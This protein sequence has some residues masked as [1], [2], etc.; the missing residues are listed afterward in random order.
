MVFSG[1]STAQVLPA[2][3]A[4]EDSVVQ[5]P[6]NAFF[7]NRPH[8][9]SLVVEQIILAGNRVTRRP[10]IHRELDFRQ[11]S[12][13]ALADT[14]TLIANSRNRLYNTRLFITVSI[15]L[16]P[17]TADSSVCPRPVIAILE[18]KERWYIFPV[19]IF[20]L[21]D[22]SINEWIYNQGADI[23]RINYGARI[24]WNNF[25]GR[26]ESVKLILQTGFTRK[27]ELAYA[28]PYIGQKQRQGFSLNLFHDSNRSISVAS[29]GNK[30]KFIRDGAKNI[31][32]RYRAG[33]GTSF[34]T[35]FYQYHST[36][37]NYYYSRVSDSVVKENPDY[38]YKGLNHQGYVSLHYHY[39]I[40]RRD[41]RQ[42]P[43]HGGYFRTGF[44]QLIFTNSGYLSSMFVSGGKF[45]DLGARF[46]TAHAA[47]GTLS[48]PRR[49]PY[50]VSRFLGFQQNFVRGYEKYVLEGFANA[51]VKN[52]V[53][54]RLFQNTIH[55]R[56]MP[57]RQFS[58]IP[59][60]LYVKGYSDAGFVRNPFAAPENARLLNTFLWGFGGGLDLVTYY[61]SVLRMEYSLNRQGES[62]FYLQM[63]VE[64]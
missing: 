8:C 49:Q 46:Y 30:Q 32:W 11:G 37:I 26:A 15:K 3:S 35:G 18:F 24:E 34:R 44:D 31:V 25:R 40:D 38:F 48:S 7:L 39:S 52:T 22:R 29:E 1:V 14:A 21:S 10:I 63:A 58:T 17:A 4:R 42:Y 33:I 20:E 9:D 23:R 13:I 16:V 47:S 45:F 12:K 27:L 56:Y 36:G 6:L 61:D 28:I 60:A 59:I 53:R 41:I 57:I 43:L 2:D 62:G 55:L 5:L 51:V 64:I 50:S 54:Y 19:P